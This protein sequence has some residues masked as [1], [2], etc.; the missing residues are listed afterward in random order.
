MQSHFNW[1]HLLCANRI[2]GSMC[3][4][5]SKELLKFAF[6]IL[7]DKQ[8]LLNTISTWCSFWG[9]YL[10]TS[11]SEHK[12]CT[13]FSYLFCLMKLSRKYFHILLFSWNFKHKL[14]STFLRLYS[15]CLW[16]FPLGL[17]DWWSMSPLPCLWFLGKSLLLSHLPIS[18]PFMVGSIMMGERGTTL[19]AADCS[20]DDRSQG[21]WCRP[22]SP[23]WGN[24]N[25]HH[26]APP[27]QSLSSAS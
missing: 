16:K 13:D 12:R 17:Q 26:W 22:G 10:T 9:I 15:I 19:E 25:K 20:Q 18:D 3:R 1:K 4:I 7:S 6:Q 24:S 23:K 27:L 14:R 2:G 8:I 21:R 5:S 11:Y